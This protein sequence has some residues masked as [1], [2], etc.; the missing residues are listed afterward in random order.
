LLG[1]YTATKTL[2]LLL[3]NDYTEIVPYDGQE[4]LKSKII[5]YFL[6]KQVLTLTSY[7]ILA[8]LV[9]SLVY[10]SPPDMKSTFG[11]FFNRFNITSTTFIH[12]DHTRAE[13][14]RNALQIYFWENGKYPDELEDLVVTNILRKKEIIN[15]NG[16]L[17]TYRSQGLSYSLN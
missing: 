14:V 6:G 5:N 9:V 11:L 17:Y 7:A 8:M 2:K 13:K 16:G 4:I 3:E 15:S 1:K 10:V 12:T